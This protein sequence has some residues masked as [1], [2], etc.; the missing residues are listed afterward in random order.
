MELLFFKKILLIFNWRMTALQ[1]CVGFCH[2]ATR[3]S[4]RYAH[5]PP[6]PRLPPASLPIPSPGVTGH[7]ADSHWLWLFHTWWCIRLHATLS[8]SPALTPIEKA[9]APHCRTLAWKIPWTEEPNGLQSMG[10]RRVGHDWA[11]LLSLFTFMRWRRRWQ[12]TPVFSPGE[13]QGR[14]PGGLNHMKLP[15]L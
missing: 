8:T 5:V 14:E 10:S 12:P 1:Y 9:M 2:T 4:H 11:T 15:F 13:S 6:P 7:A 3:I